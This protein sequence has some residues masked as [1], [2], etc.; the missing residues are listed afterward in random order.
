MT[1][2][3][4]EKVFPT[5]YKTENII[6]KVYV[7]ICLSLKLAKKWAVSVA[8]RGGR[9]SLNELMMKNENEEPQWSLWYFRLFP[10]KIMSPLISRNFL[11]LLF[12]IGSFLSIVV[13]VK[14]IVVMCCWSWSELIKMKDCF[15]WWRGCNSSAHFSRLRCCSEPQFDIHFTK[16]ARVLPLINWLSIINFDFKVHECM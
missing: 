9:G 2:W 7:V 13:S 12:F 14:S 16:T 5:P 11:T 15:W 8:V 3:K 1:D 4:N 10:K 6:V